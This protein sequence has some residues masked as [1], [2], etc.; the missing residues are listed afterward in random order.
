MPSAFTLSNVDVLGMSGRDNDCQGDFI[1]IEGENVVVCI[2]HLVL[3]SPYRVSIDKFVQSM[4]GKAKP[5]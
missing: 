4:N 3:N 2:G 1:S 5:V